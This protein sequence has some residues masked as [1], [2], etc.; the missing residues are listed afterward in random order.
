MK[1]HDLSFLSWYQLYPPLLSSR[2]FKDQISEHAVGVNEASYE[3]GYLNPFSWVRTVLKI[4]HL[5]PKLVI[6]SWVHPVHAPVYI[7]MISLFRLLV[8]AKI[9][10][11]CHNVLPHEGFPG[12][13]FLSKITYRL[14]DRLVVHSA[15]EFSKASQLVDS[16]R[17]LKLFLPLYNF[18]QGAVETSAA[19]LVDGVTRLLF[20]GVVRDYKGVDLLLQALS[21]VVRQVKQVHLTIAGEGLGGEDDQRVR[22][23]VQ[24]LNL[25]SYVTLDQRY[26]PNE[27]VAG[28]FEAANVV[29]L[30]YRSVTG[31]GPLMAAYNYGKPVI[32]TRVGGFIEHIV[33]GQSGYLCDVDAESIAQAI[34]KFIAAPLA[35]EGVNEIAKNYTFKRYTHELLEF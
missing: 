14:V 32:A 17:V 5:K 24:D 31:S 35:E 25:A 8:S 4:A 27:E 18:S 10:L 2:N 26:I 1:V 30:P 21:K 34:I 16:G 28:M 29:V 13:R 33:D 12:S 3:L 11:I 23:L 6:L 22:A 7:T 19:S 15:E 20:F 9:V